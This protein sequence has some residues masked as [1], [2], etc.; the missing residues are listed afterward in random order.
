MTT[1][2]TVTNRMASICLLSPFP[3]IANFF[4][5]HYYL[6]FMFVLVVAFLSKGFYNVYFHNLRHIPGPFLG[7]FTDFY[8]VYIFACRHI[9]SGTMELHQQFGSF[10]VSICDYGFY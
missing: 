7:G 10:S 1:M 9:P 3:A 5:Y 2:N 4:E 8:K 6:F